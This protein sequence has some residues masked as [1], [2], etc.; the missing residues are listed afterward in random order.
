MAFARFLVYINFFDV[1]ECTQVLK[2]GKAEELF[3]SLIIPIHGCYHAQHQ[4]YVYLRYLVVLEDRTSFCRHQSTLDRLISCLEIICYLG[5]C[6]KLDAFMLFKVFDK[7]LKCNLSAQFP[8]FLNELTCL[9]C[10]SI[11]C[12]RPDTCESIRA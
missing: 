4:C 9:S 10:I 12:G 1:Y 11:A 7:P 6:D 3:K 5:H 2:D 8:Y